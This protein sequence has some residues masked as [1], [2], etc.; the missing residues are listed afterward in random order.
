MA[1]RNPSTATHH[2]FHRVGG[3]GGGPSTATHLGFHRGGGGTLQQLRTMAFTGGRNPSTATH[4]GFHRVEG[5]GT[6]QQLPTMAFREG[7]GEEPFN[8]Y[9][10]WLSQGGGVE[11]GGEPF[12]SYAP[13]LSLGG[14]GG[15]NPSTATHHG[16]HSLQGR[17]SQDLKG[18]HRWWVI[19]LLQSSLVSSRSRCRRWCGRTGF[20]SLW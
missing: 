16:F 12:N 5:G 7:G 2:G 14:G 20:F 13:W 3:G 10:P 6:L 1:G 17:C 18:V 15:R 8:S 11:G 9:P 4:H 19:A